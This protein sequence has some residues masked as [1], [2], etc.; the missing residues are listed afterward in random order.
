MIENVTPS[1]PLAFLDHMWVLYSNLQSLFS[2]RLDIRYCNSVNGL[3][4]SSTDVIRELVRNEE[5]K[6]PALT[7]QMRICIS[8]SST[9]DLYAE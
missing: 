1:I 6:A 5:S 9:S 3:R 4:A 8:T 2:S 7:F